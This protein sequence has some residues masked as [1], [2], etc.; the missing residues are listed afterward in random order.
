MTDQTAPTRNTRR[1]RQCALVSSVIPIALIIG[2][3][4][5]VAGPAAG[6][7]LD[8][9]TAVVV[10][11]DLG[12]DDV[13]ALAM[14]LHFARG[15]DFGCGPAPALA[16]M[17]EEGGCVMNL[18]DPFYRPDRGSLGQSYQ[19]ITATEVVEHLHRPGEELAA[20]WEALEPG[21]PPPLPSQSLGERLAAVAAA[22]GEEKP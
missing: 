16:A 14:I 3:L 5:S 4:V 21:A 18:Y 7:E 9:Q 2:A 17:L 13:V 22:P 20:L 6:H 1:G 19:F 8:T 12:L 10:D 11:T 15:L